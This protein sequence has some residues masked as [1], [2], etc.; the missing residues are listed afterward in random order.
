[1]VAFEKKEIHS[2]LDAESRY[3]KELDSG[4]SS[5]LKADSTGMTGIANRT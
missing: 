4:S 2:A 5:R 1:M 3:I